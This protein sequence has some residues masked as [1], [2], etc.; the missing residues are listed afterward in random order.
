MYYTYTDI[1][2]DSE[3]RNMYVFIKEIIVKSWYIYSLEYLQNMK[4]SKSELY[5]LIWKDVYDILGKKA[6]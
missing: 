5:A 3:N 1:T 2:Y 4:N 6:N